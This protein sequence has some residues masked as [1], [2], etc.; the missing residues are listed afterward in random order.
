MGFLSSLGNIINN[1]FG[2]GENDSSEISLDTDML[3][4]YGKQIDKTS[5]R[6]YIEDGFVRNFRPRTR[7]VIFQQP[8]IVI[9]IKK[10]MF[11][12]IVSNS[13]RELLDEKELLLLAA[14]K[15]LFQNKCKLVSAYEKLTKIEK[16]TLQSGSFNTYLGPQLFQAIDIINPALS[17]MGIGINS[18]TAA[19]FEKLRRIIAY[20][21]PSDF[22]TW[23]TNSHDSVFGND[24]GEGTGTFEITTATDVSTSASV[25]FGGGNASFTLEDPYQ[26]GRITIQDI[27]QAIS[28]MDQFKDNRFFKFAE[29]ESLQ[30]IDSLKKELYTIRAA[31][32]A[33]NITF[34]T[35]EGSVF[36]KKIKAI[37]DEEGIEI[38]YTYTTGLQESFNSFEKS[39]NA[40]SVANSIGDLF[41]T[42]AIQVDQAYL[43][44]SGNKL[45]PK[46]FG[47]FTNLLTLMYTVFSY[48]ATSQK[49]LG[50]I[51]ANVNNVRNRMI[52]MFNGRYIIQPMDVVNIFMTT[53]TS[54]DDRLTKDF[55]NVYGLNG[56]KTAEK[57]DSII[58]NINTSI[59]SWKGDSFD[60]LEK[61]ATV[62]ADFPTWLWRM[63][64]N[65]ITQ[66][67]AG[68][69]IFV[70]LC[71]DSRGEHHNG[72]FTIKINCE[73]NT[74]Y[75]E[76][77][78]INF[79]P[80]ADVYNSTIYD[81]L[82][83]FDISFDASTGIPITQN[84]AGQFPPLLKENQ[85][86]LQ[87]GALIFKNGPNK[88]QKATP[89]LIQKNHQDE[90]FNNFRR[91]FYSPDGLVYRWKQGIQTST[92]SG[93]PYPKSSTESERSIKLTNQP[94]AGQ[95][96]MNVISILI[97][98]QPYNYSS[99]LKA[100]IKN[101]N[102]LAPF[103][104]TKPTAISYLE[105]LL[106]DI[107]KNNAIW[108]NF[109][110][111]KKLIIDSSLNQ[112]I[113]K[114]QNDL[115]NLNTTLAQK[116]RDRARLCDEESILNRDLV[117]DPRGALVVDANG[118]L[119][120]NDP[121]S[122]AKVT[123]NFSKKLNEL[124]ADITKSQTAYLDTI[125]DLQAPNK[126]IGITLIGNEIDSN[127][128]IGN[129]N[130]ARTEDQK[131]FD[132]LELRRKL[133]TY[134]LRRLWEVKANQDQNLF[135]VDD[136][137]DK[138]FDIMAFERSISGNQLEVFNNDY[139]TIRD[140]LLSASGILGLEI[141]ANTQG[142]IEI[143]PPSYN[144]MPS[145]VF[146]QMFRD[147]DS[148]GIRVFP[149]FL[150]SLYFNQIQGL[151][152]KIE[153]LEDQIRL[154]SISLGFYDDENIKANLIKSTKS[155]TFIFITKQDT[156]LISDLY[157]LSKPA[158][159]DFEVQN[160]ALQTATGLVNQ[161]SKISKTTRLFDTDVQTQLALNLKLNLNISDL[162]NK[163]EAIRRRLREK[164]GTEPPKII[165]LYTNNNGRP[166]SPL[167]ELDKI[168][169]IS[170]LSN[171]ISEHQILI[172]S[173][174]NTL[175]NIKEGL[176][177]NLPTQ[178][179]QVLFSGGLGNIT[180]TSDG[181]GNSGQ[182][183]STPWLYRRTGIPQPLDHMIE[184]EEDDDL[185]PSSGKRFVIKGH[186]Y[187][188]LSLTE[189]QPPFTAIAV[190]GLP[191]E[192][193]V[194][195]PA[196]FKTSSDGN[197]LSTAY[198]VDY[199]MWYMYGFKT[200]PA[201]QAPFFKDPETQC[202]PF[203]VSNLIKARE[204]IL[205]GEITVHGYNEFYQPGDVVYIEDL[206]L[207]FYVNSV[208]HNFQYGQSVSTRLR[209]TYGHSP[210]E[211]IPNMLDIIG[212]ILYNAKG[213]TGQFRIDR[214]DTNGSM[215]KIGVIVYNTGYGNEN[216][217]TSDI[218]KSDKATNVLFTGSYGK[219]NLN[220]LSNALLAVSGALNQVT[221]S[222]VKANI[223][224]RYYT[225]SISENEIKQAAIL[226][227]E[228]LVNPQIFSQ[229]SQKMISGS[230]NIKTHG[231]NSS[232]V[233]IEK[234]DLDKSSYIKINESANVSSMSNN[235]TVA[236][237]DEKESV[238][239]QGPSDA[240]WAAAR[241]L[242]GSNFKPDD[243]KKFM[244]K[245]VIDI[246]VRYTYP[247]ETQTSN[248][249]NSSQSGQNDANSVSAAKTA[250]AAS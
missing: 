28:D 54:E 17:T 78:K 84:T 86:L 128:T 161:F 245:S 112:F 85:I 196:S 207:L 242:V 138:N 199:D 12:S 145:S 131:R 140:Q 203:A 50:N 155:N 189:N 56:L 133:K 174:L 208:S 94:F 151:Y 162:S 71:K 165:D 198:A 6:N 176:S 218:T 219:R 88:G 109:I 57:F 24:I 100:S 22:T 16:F 90:E 236:K 123:N 49:K 14:S 241:E 191:Y 118:Y 33:S 184:Y 228:W 73:D 135:I 147:K 45:N 156:G 103:D 32:G 202:A 146:Y 177:V 37:V 98:G 61:T 58:K 223:V 68:T 127:P 83:P 69:A 27:D 178:K 41:S 113:G 2:T 29:V 234:V 247:E 238:N 249:D 179:N 230:S 231:L 188:D 126:Q 209:L 76:K 106:F 158:T 91:V 30:K 10:R 93:R 180:K 153:I 19:A 26:L 4:N 229:A 20:S 120:Q 43:G 183:A 225:P 215:R 13:K 5:E 240:A 47:I 193:F 195:T 66:P 25:E 75:L 99:F 7:E 64:R 143:K 232:D 233:I 122:T 220:M 104:S 217:I 190:N 108:G 152:Q 53:K 169:I 11:S 171:L 116:L 51:T 243:L 72:K 163:A 172:K 119:K 89:L 95:D 21:D 110:P 1:Q 60:D 181:I 204:N 170:Q 31:R 8:D 36:D 187:S 101:G 63:Y 226:I 139:T 166:G 96:V 221:L 70:G 185:G 42:G 224:L 3:G 82:T 15:K 250:G 248:A 18:N 167:S 136:Q 192:G 211:Y 239:E 235:P 182:S 173:T 62:G 124:N 186:Q 74:S 237:S 141:F 130:D 121:Q 39:N 159:P 115:I 201:M 35:S 59:S 92:F 40:D 194:D 134:T 244:A 34:I 200:G 87:T 137:Y 213:V 227:K 157:N 149:E 129:A 48:R 160:Q 38:I 97:T 132:E 67:T 148:K 150:E 9:V 144:K 212:K 105:G 55:H 80:S 46:E 222:R 164:T 168:N 175:K 117:L 107:Q 81:P 246:F 216:N 125:K 142:H 206:N 77:G 102:N 111:F 65:Q 210:G 154:R 79:Q 205:N 197:A 52:L 23:T 44:N 114:T 214:Y